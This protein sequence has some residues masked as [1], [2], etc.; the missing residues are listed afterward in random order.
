[1]V[2]IIGSLT[3]PQALE[4]HSTRQLIRTFH[5]Y[6]RPQQPLIYSFPP[7]YSAYFYSQENIQLADRPDSLQQALA[8]PGNLI[9]VA[10][11]KNLPPSIVYQKLY[12]NG[13]SSLIQ[14]KP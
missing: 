8:V 3:L 2:I 9:V 14:I 5:T 1:M 4:T 12:E 13:K 7:P 11:E 6:A 10:S